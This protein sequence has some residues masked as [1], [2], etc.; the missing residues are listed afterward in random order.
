MQGNFTDIKAIIRNNK[1][2]GYQFFDPKT[3]AFWGSAVHNELYGGCVFVTKDDDF[4][5]NT[6]Y[7]VRVAM[8]DGSIHSY[9]FNEFETSADAHSKAK[10]IGMAIVDGMLSWRDADKNFVDSTLLGL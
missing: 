4:Q 9:A 3:M 2:Q 7:S 8:D 1:R 6:M 10:Q 5:R